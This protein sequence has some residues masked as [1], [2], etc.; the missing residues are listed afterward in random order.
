MNKIYHFPKDFLW[1]GATAANQLEGGHNE[2]GKGPNLAD[3]LPGGKSRRKLLTQPGFD[4]ELDIEK[5]TY[6]NH[7]AIDFYHRY[8]EDIALFA[9]MGFKVFRMSIAWSRIFPKGDEL[10]PN[11]EGLAFYDRVFDELHKHGIEPL[12][13]IAHYE[14]PL[15]LIKEYGGW[16]N[17]KLIEFFERYVKVLFNRYKDKVKYW[18]T[19]NEIN[20]ATHF[21][22][23]GLGFSATSEEMR[24]QETFQGL[25]H[26]FV[27]S[28][29]A[30]QL[31]HQVIPGSQIGCML[32]YASTYSYDSNPENVMHALEDGRIFNFFCGDVQVRGEYPSFINRYF[33]ENDI[34]IDIQKGD[35][36]TIKEG[37]VDFISLSYY[38]S[39]TEKKEKTPEEL[40]Q[41]NL[42]GG[43]KNPFLKA[44]DWG[45]EI[46]PTGLRVALNE[47]YGRYQKPLMVVENGLGAYDKV[48]E[49]GSINDDYRIDYLR[50]HIK[51]MG[52]AIEDGVDLIGY[53]SWGCID[54]VSA[55]TGEYS[56]RYGFIY[57]DKHDD[58]SGTLERS[59]KKSFYWYKDVI[60]SNGENL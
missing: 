24:L 58:G 57:V 2:G 39:R 59:R 40:G 17:R 45:W 38:M 37:T 48:E 12:V 42:I 18:L 29:I 32:L 11:E 47:L 13:T 14:T 56:K 15:H 34:K 25:H 54:L 41:G 31:G 1:G 7:E 30:V 44:S 6:P 50:D 28:A 10:E 19:F 16:K 5:Y 46:D 22:L 27:A 52:E 8:K 60:S 35:L 53:T 20:S 4:F 3:V 49:D 43:V 55:S 33:K 36:E 51:A 21:P 9:E 26:Q 23:F